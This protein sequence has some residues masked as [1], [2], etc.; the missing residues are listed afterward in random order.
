MLKLVSAIV[1]IFLISIQTIHADWKESVRGG[2][3][4]T[5]DATK[6]GWDAAVDATKSGWDATVDATKGA[7]GEGNQ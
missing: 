3:D 4:S 2:W 6:E 5:L 1:C 7:V